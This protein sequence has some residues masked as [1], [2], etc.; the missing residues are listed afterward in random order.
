MY[1]ETLATMMGHT[2]KIFVGPS[3]R[4]KT[5]EER[6]FTQILSP[7]SMSSYDR[8]NKIVESSI[9]CWNLALTSA[10]LCHLRA[11][12]VIAVRLSQLSL[13]G[14]HEIQSRTYIRTSMYSPHISW[15]Q[16]FACTRIVQ[17]GAVWGF[18]TIRVDHRIS[19]LMRSHAKFS[20]V[21]RN[22]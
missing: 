3:D 15:G 11:L 21:P 12:C 5:Y 16:A 1:G 8:S 14:S 7:C 22:I 10:V 6:H 17:L 4:Q 13:Y 19:S 20:L 9:R 18:P 2:R